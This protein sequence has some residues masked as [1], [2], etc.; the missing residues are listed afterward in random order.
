MPVKRLLGNKLG[1]GMQVG[2]QAC[3]RLWRKPPRTSRFNRT[4]QTLCP[5]ALASR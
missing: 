3:L 4:N 2:L 1:Q 5:G